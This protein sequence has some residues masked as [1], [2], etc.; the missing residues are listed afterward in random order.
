MST[1]SLCNC[2]I[3]RRA[4]PSRSP[5]TFSNW[6]MPST[7]DSTVSLDMSNG[8]GT[9]A[10]AGAV[11]RFPFDRPVRRSKARQD[12]FAQ[13]KIGA[14]APIPGRRRAS[15]AVDRRRRLHNTRWPTS[16]PAGTP[17]RRTP[18]EAANIRRLR[19]LHG[20]GFD[21]LAALQTAVPAKHET[22]AARPPGG[23]AAPKPTVRALR[24]EHS[25]ARIG[26]AVSHGRRQRERQH[27]QCRQV[28]R[29]GIHDRAFGE[30][31]EIGLEQRVVP[32]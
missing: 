23:A 3:R 31:N 13:M 24:V 14:H 22:R 25:P 9:T 28:E 12:S 27:P 7:H 2:D 21:G 26:L 15:N 6:R 18:G 10:S 1:F 4:H 11:D 32:R 8:Y 5:S 29:V 17:A 19:S 20:I 30:S 16:C